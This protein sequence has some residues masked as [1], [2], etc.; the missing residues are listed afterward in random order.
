MKN[1]SQK[2]NKQL[3]NYEQNILLPILMNGLQN[4]KGKQ[5]TITNRQMV[6][7]LKR[8]G[9]QIN[10]NTVCRIVNFIRTN[11]LI[12]GLVATTHGYYVSDTEEEFKEYE[13]HLLKREVALRKVRK[14]IERQRQTLFTP[15]PQ[16][17][18][19]F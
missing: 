3:T 8:K 12:V 16:H 1:V 15:Q 5:N 2:M 14:C 18:A 9:L 19:L 10:L 17:N 6:E 11:D 13:R 4:K 7:V